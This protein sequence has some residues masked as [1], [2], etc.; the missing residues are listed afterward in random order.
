MAHWRLPIAPI[1]GKQLEDE[2][3]SFSMYVREY[4]K[5]GKQVWVLG[6]IAGF[7]E[8]FVEWLCGRHIETENK[9]KW[10]MHVISYVIVTF[11]YVITYC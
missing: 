11:Y 6:H 10:I 8:G 5:R 3:S 4:V 2:D 7:F 1:L 9:T